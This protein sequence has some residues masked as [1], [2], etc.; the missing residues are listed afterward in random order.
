M[1][2]AINGF[3]RIGRSILRLAL[4]S[5][6]VEV[7]LINDVAPIETCGY[8]FEFDSTF[9]TWPG[10]VEVIGSTLRVDDRIIPF[11]QQADISG[12]D[13]QGVDVLLECSGQP[14]SV[15]TA[16]TGVS[17]G[18][19]RALIS[20]PASLADITLVLG[21]NEER[22]RGEAVV[23]NASC[24]TNALPP[25]LRIL[26]DTFSVIGGQM[27]TVHCYTG[28]Q[29]T[30]DQP[31]DD[32]ARSR[33][34]AL[35]MVPTTTSAHRLLGTVLPGLAGR[36]EARALR[37]PTASVSAIDLTV[38]IR[39]RTDIESIR[40]ILFDAVERSDVIGWIEKPLVSSDLRGRPE[41]LVISGPELSLAAAG[42]LL[43]IF[44][45]YDNEW[46]FANRMLDMARHIS[47]YEKEDQP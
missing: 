29:P 1:R 11:F 16:R 20:G 5:P 12:L 27:T 38:S 3:G 42:G 40:H 32:L 34:A 13:L 44:G 39:R 45:W 2:V 23:S 22:Y 47:R 8:L 19:A 7:V 43:R 14:N 25:I 26:D 6:D 18:A 15:E 10:D 17:L 33:A 46:G 24:T 21:A 28:S 36:I 9:G 35:S 41:S 4:R 30:V 31:R 37:V